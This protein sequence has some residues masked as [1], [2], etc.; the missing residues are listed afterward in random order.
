MIDAASRTLRVSSLDRVIF[1]ATERNAAVTEL[2]IVKY[3]LSVEHGTMRA[4]ERRPTSLGARRRA[5]TEGSTTEAHARRGSDQ[6]LSRT[7]G[8]E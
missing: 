6:R 7:P 8:S 5:S 2:D 4:F 1:S 3:N